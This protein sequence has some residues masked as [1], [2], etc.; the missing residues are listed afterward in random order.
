MGDKLNKAF[1]VDQTGCAGSKVEP[2]KFFGWTGAL[3]G[4]FGT[5]LKAFDQALLN[6]SASVYYLTPLRDYH[7]NNN[8]AILNP[9]W[10]P[11]SFSIPSAFSPWLQT[12]LL[13]LSLA[14]TWGTRWL[15]SGLPRT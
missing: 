9:G 12:G 5:V 14:Q 1:K 3:N 7:N 13:A 15:C 2:R 8:K 4:L 6:W 10:Y 11:F